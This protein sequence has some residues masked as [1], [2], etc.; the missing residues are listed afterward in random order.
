M[1]A[2]LDQKAGPSTF[3]LH[4]KS[5]GDERRWSQ[6]TSIRAKL[7]AILFI[8]FIV[9]ATL[10]NARGNRYADWTWKSHGSGPA[11]TGVD[12]DTLKGSQY[13]LGVGKADIT[14]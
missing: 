6:K 7:S 4:G 12:F 2:A 10:L 11:S 5:E 8:I 13:L 1:D 3:R 14:G 9:S